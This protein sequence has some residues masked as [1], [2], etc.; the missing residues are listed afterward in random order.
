MIYFTSDLH[1]YHRNIIEYSNRPFSSLEEMNFKLIENINNTVDYDDTLYILGDFSF[2]T[3]ARSLEIIKTINCN[4]II[5]TQGNHDQARFVNK[6]LS[7]N[8][9]ITA[10]FINERPCF[11]LDDTRVHFNHTPSL[12]SDIDT[13]IYLHG[14]IHTE[15]TETINKQNHYDVGVDNNSFRPISLQKLRNLLNF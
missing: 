1:L 14:H 2:T 5:F 15:G 6:L 13:N 10:Y 8:K 9:N 12:E 11:E 4:N 7:L 3:V